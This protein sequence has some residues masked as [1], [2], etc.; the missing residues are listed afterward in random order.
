[1]RI[2]EVSAANGIYVNEY[3]KHGD[4]VELYNTTDH[5]IDVRGMYLSDN[6]N[7]LKKYQ[8]ASPLTTDGGD[9]Q[10]PTVIPAH[11]YL[12]I[13]CDKLVPLTQF[14]TSFKLAAEG[15]DVLLT[16]IDESWGDRLTYT[17]MTDDQT[18][19][20]YP[21]GTD[22][23]YMMNIPTIGK[24]NITSSYVTFVEQENPVVTGISDIAAA[25]SL[26]VRYANGRLVVEINADADIRV[27]VANLSGQNVLATTSCVSG[28]RADVGVSQLRSGIYVAIVSDNKGNKAACKFVIN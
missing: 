27:S 1:M 26:Q 9:L 24:A 16:A 8:I 14:H 28:G 5:P 2:N 12:V 17:M 25:N 23:V 19:G 6:P 18:A 4:W 10:S 7:K 22:D 21:D 20:R 3:F 15:G 11:G 13:W